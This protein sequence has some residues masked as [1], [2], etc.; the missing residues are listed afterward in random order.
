MS[1]TRGNAKGMTVARWI[2]YSLVALAVI[3][4][5]LRPMPMKFE[6]TPEAKS[7]FEKI[8]AFKPGA[9]VLLSFDYDPASSAELDPM[10]KAL[11]VH[12]FKKGLIPIVMTHWASGL[13]NDKKT[14]EAAVARAR[15]VMKREAPFVSGRDYVFLG[16][17]PGYSNLILN[18]GDNLK[19]AF[20]KDYFGESTATMSALEGVGSLRNIDMVIDLAAGATVEMWIAFGSDRFGFP[21]GVGS[22][23]VQAPNLYPYLQSKQICGFLGGLRGA[24]DYEQ[25]VEAPGDG[26]RGMQGQS[27]AHVLLIGIIV[28]ANARMLIGRHRRKGKD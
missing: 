17:R 11:L 1:E 28:F 12:C 7:L 26:V 24:A 13:D 9:H 19:G 16:F 27:L 25:L 15:T 5:Y 6:A 10:A 4:P 14:I 23:A 3:L 18:M 8:Q 22:V 2:I 20:D 21:L